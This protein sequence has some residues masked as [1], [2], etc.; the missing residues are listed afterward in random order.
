MDNIQKMQQEWAAS[1]QQDDDNIEL[2]IEA[3][4]QIKLLKAEQKMRSFL[5]MNIF[6]LVVGVFMISFLCH[7]IYANID[8]LSMVLA[9][10]VVLVWSC[11]I[12][13]GGIVHLY[14]QLTLDYSKPVTE[15]QTQLNKISLSVLYYLKVSL[16]IL[17]FYF[18]YIVI[19]FKLFGGVDIV[20]HGDATWLVSQGLCS[21][22][23]GLLAIYLYK[24][25]APSKLNKPLTQMLLKSCGSQVW[26]AS[27]ELGELQEYS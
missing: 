9:G 19:G 5:F 13:V 14:M 22:V 20:Q 11:F 1:Q 16:L 18:A 23:F 15:V 27:K 24:Q 25:L 21:V 2:N 10:L 12:S 17:P 26:L 4:K 8:N 7:F 6:T 3:L